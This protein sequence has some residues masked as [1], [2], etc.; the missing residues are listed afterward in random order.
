MGAIVGGVVAASD[1][2][3]AESAATVV[4]VAALA[5]VAAAGFAAA[6]SG[7]VVAAAVAWEGEGNRIDLAVRVCM[8][9]FRCW[10]ACSHCPD[11]RAGRRTG[12]GN[13]PGPDSDQCNAH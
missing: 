13:Q 5:A 10:R 4:V 12:F 8:S 3:A 6:G 9:H 1:F 7:L 11:S 2:V